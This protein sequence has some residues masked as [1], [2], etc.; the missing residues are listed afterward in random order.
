LGKA[1]TY[2]RMG[3]SN[4][5][6]RDDESDT[7]DPAEK[8][9][10]TSAA[11]SSPR[12]WATCPAIVEV[13]TASEIFVL[14][15]VH[16]D[17]KKLVAL[18]T[19][20]NIIA[21]AKPKEYKWT[22]G[23]AILLCTG[24]LIDKWTRSVKVLL[25]FKN[26]QA[27]AQKAGGQVIVTCGNHEV[28]FLAGTRTTL[29]SEEKKFAPFRAELEPL[30]ITEQD[31][32]LSKDPLGL[33]VILRSMPFAARINDWFFAHAGNTKGFSISDLRTRLQVAGDSLYE[34]V[35]SPD[36]VLYSLVESRLHPHPWWEEGSPNPATAVLTHNL[37]MLGCKHIV[38]GHQPGKVEFE[39]GTKRKKD[40]MFPV[41]GGLLFL[42]DI[43]MSRGVHDG[44]TNGSLLHITKEEATAFYPP[45]NSFKN[46]SREPLWPKHKSR[47]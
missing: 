1:Y 6:P 37:D 24:D 28:E 14:G 5:R 45:D 46:G 18:L 10:K 33:G 9:P 26:L 2:L 8:E 19:F 13:D 44:L 15:D 20:A 22:A 12:D 25:L 30:G 42:I 36:S 7:P 38:M 16:G 31:V 34:T 4:K 17:H 21:K 3:D 47:K 29:E 43:G 27:Q 39:D 40:T 23:N 35:R 41:F 32:R 11:C